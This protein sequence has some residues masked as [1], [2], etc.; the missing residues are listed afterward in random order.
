M[1]GEVEAAGVVA[2]PE[3]EGNEVVVVGVLGDQFVVRQRLRLSVAKDVAGALVHEFRERLRAAVRESLHH[4]ARVVVV[5]LI[6]FVELF[7]DAGAGGHRRTRERFAERPRYDD[8]ETHKNRFGRSGQE[9]Q[10][11]KGH[12]AEPPPLGSAVDEPAP[13]E[14]KPWRPHCA[15]EVVGQVQHR[16]QIAADDECERSAGRGDQLETAGPKKQP[17]AAKRDEVMG[18]EEEIETERKR[19]DEKDARR[20]KDAGVEAGEE[21]PRLRERVVPLPR[22]RRVG[23][24]TGERDGGVEVA[25]AAGLDGEV[26]RLEHDRQPGGREVAAGVE[27]RAELVRRVVALLAAVA[28]EGE[29]VGARP[30]PGVLERA[31]R[32]GEAGLHVTRPPPDDPPVLPPRLAVGALRTKA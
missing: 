14:E 27:R 6:E 3:D 5:L 24:P 13:G 30:Q 15:L 7:L 16:H 21:R 9:L 1:A 22:P 17:C 10:R 18:D 28:D 19:Q 2:L 31:Q 26:G 25:H 12:E 4:D 23:R 11:E 8:R 29:V 32:H 20:V